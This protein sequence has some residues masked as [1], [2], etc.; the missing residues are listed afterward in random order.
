[1]TPTALPSRRERAL[2][3]LIRSRFKSWAR[4]ALA[5][6]GQQPAA[7]HLAVIDALEAVERGDTDRLMV[8]LPPGSA[9][10]TFASMLFPAWWMA[11]HPE[12]SV[13]TASHTASLAEHFGRTVRSLLVEHGV[14]L[15]LDMRPDARAAGRFLTSQGGEYFAIGVNG[16]V[17]GRR[18]DLALIDDP[19]RCF[20]DAESLAARDHLWNWFRTE[21]MTRLKPGGRVV[22]A[23][24]RWHQD[25]IAG[26]LIEQGGWQILRLPALAETDDP[27]GRDEGAALWPEWETR[28][29]LLAKQMSIGDLSFA[30]MYQQTPALHGG[31]IF[32]IGRIT[33]ADTIPDGSAVRAWDL[34]SGGTSTGNPDWTAGVRLVRTTGS[35]FWVDDVVR[36]RVAPADIDKAIL[37]TARQ[38]GPE[39]RIGLPRDPGQAGGYQAT[40]L[41]KALVGYRVVST[42]ETGSK[43]FRAGPVASQVNHGLLGLRRAGWNR[44][45]LDELGAFPNGPKDDQVDALSRAFAMLATA[46]PA[47]HYID[48]THFAR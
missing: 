35:Q 45:L 34:A 3:R 6:R 48:S 12:H 2:R 20:A 23:M 11:R 14:T 8:L 38:D 27:L 5:D 30:A 24:T 4:F 39:T 18:A 47:A 9:K 40:M 19:V 10:S 15:S 43:L 22:L 36:V 7:H 41:A 16:G 17:T 29:Q 37:Q 42:P 13:I 26:R 28:S 21:L 31:R 25:D 32:D 1:M 33:I 46:T 44:A